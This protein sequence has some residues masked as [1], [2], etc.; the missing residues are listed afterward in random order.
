MMM[1]YFILILISS[2]LTLTAQDNNKCYSVQ[3]SSFLIKDIDSYTF[4]GYPESCR[5]VEI[6]GVHSVRC[7]CFE[8]YND[9]MTHQKTLEQKYPDA[10]IVETYAYRFSKD[11]KKSMADEN[12]QELRLLFQVFSYSSDLENAYLTAKKAL[13]TFP[14][15]LYW[16]N[17]MAEV[18]LW[19]GRR[20]E[21]ME[22]MM[23][24]YKR[25]HDR[26]LE[27]KIYKYALSAYQY[28]TAAVMIEKRV[29]RDPSK[30]NI[31]EMV[32]IFDLVG[33]PLES[34]EILDALYQ[35][36]TSRRYL[37]TQQLQIYLNMGEIQ[38]AEKI[39]KQID[40]EQ[41]HDIQSAF[42]CSQYYFIVRDMDAS[43]HCLKSVDLES[44]D[45][46][47][48][49]YY[50]QLSDFSWYK[51]EHEQAAEASIK[52]DEANATRLVDYER[53][54][55]VYKDKEPSRAMKA[56]LDAYE[57]F[58]QNYLFYTYA[59]LAMDLKQHQEV[60]DVCE[61]IESKRNNTLPED[62]LYW[63]IKAQ[64]YTSVNEDI[65]AKKAFEW[66]QALSPGSNEIIESYLWFL[67]D[68]KD[69]QALSRLL[70]ALEEKKKV[71]SRLWLSMAVAYFSIQEGD[72]AAYYLEMLKKNKMQSRD[73][74]LLYAYV[75]QLQNDE[76]GFYKEIRAIYK[77]MNKELKNRPERGADS[78]FMQT[79]LS[80]KMFLVGADEFEE[81][82]Q[83]AKLALKYD[84]YNALSLS[85]AQRENID[86]QVKMMAEPMKA[87]EPWIRL[88]LALT[89][90]DRQSQQDIIYKYYRSLPLGDTLS[91]ATNDMQISFA[92]SIAFEGLEKNEKNSLLY[93][94]MRNLHNE[95][96][97]SFI[98]K[99]GYL[100][101]SGVNQTY[102]DMHNSYYLAKGY[103]LETDL[104]LGRN[105]I[106]DNEVFKSI[107]SS[108]TSFGL[109]IKKRFARGSY[110]VDIGV[111]DSAD[112]YNYFSFKYQTM[113]SRRLNMELTVDKAAK[114]E[115]SV[116]LMVGGY[117]DRI[118]LQMAYSI[119]GSSTIG[120][121]LEE[122]KFSSDDGVSL[123]SGLSGRLDYSY[124]QRSAYPDITFTPYYTFGIYNEKG[125]SN[126]V[127][128]DMLTFADS[129]VIS[130]DF[131]YTGVDLSY[132]M[133]N[134]YNY[135]RVW[136]PFF[137]ISP[138]YNG[139]ESQFNYGFSA[140]LGGELFGQDNLSFIAEYAESVGG[141]TDQLW[142]TYFRYKILY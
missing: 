112:T 116:Y 33:K 48:T 46:N 132:G 103:S 39:V 99:A 66:A 13:K 73:S 95:H 62:A 5:L 47:L 109:G 118:G 25:T 52:V 76:D 70:F 108:S 111:R 54:L 125:G 77:K 69:T 92:Q 106:N 88:G 124:L 78:D 68:T 40:K 59:Y 6:N 79:Y 55:S 89:A 22:E 32:Y 104:F 18:A 29:K 105:A 42:L 2:I 121:Y 61:K 27:E 64:L 94:Q 72:R 31:E 140:G 98:V 24:V 53:I 35:K 114:A 139:R 81:S 93:Q 134:R 141:T 65:Q 138:Y 131:W 90:N 127:I 43:Y 86:E 96:A 20:Q 87:S 115:E 84:A 80:V 107:A 130:D 3:V 126:G 133:E 37:L 50:M 101:R 11:D 67:M 123:G 7:G 30:K 82:L 17:K 71:S 85:F 1:K 23:Y 21:A 97:D 83:N 57:K 34:A 28:D 36:D 117:K 12:D 8:G 44:T 15:S 16:H 100:S 56:A 14:R 120:L 75:R 49:R 26:K 9:A 113:I 10:M 60:L 4:K 102:S 38:R 142:R 135:V 119:L 136:R 122:A 91:A 51:R 74:D 129:N 128:D 58:S 41:M 45:E 110:Q 19:T 137:S 63:M